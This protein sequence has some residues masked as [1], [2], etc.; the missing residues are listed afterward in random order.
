MTLT[1]AIRMTGEALKGGCLKGHGDFTSLSNLFEFRP[2]S[3]AYKAQGRQKAPS[4][5]FEYTN[6][7]KVFYNAGLNLRFLLPSFHWGN[8]KSPSGFHTFVSTSHFL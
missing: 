5:Y 8:I 2:H 6:Q 3:L 4:R 1:F 7:E